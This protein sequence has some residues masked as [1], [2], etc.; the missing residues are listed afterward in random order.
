MQLLH[1]F[2]EDDEHD[3]QGHMDDWFGHEPPSGKPRSAVCACGARI[4]YLDKNGTVGAVYHHRHW[5]PW[6]ELR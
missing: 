1:V 4:V 3:R 6:K 2:Q 5:S